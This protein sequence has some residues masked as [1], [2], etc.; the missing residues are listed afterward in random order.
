MSEQPN[1]GFSPESTPISIEQIIAENHARIIRMASELGFREDS[2]MQEIRA[3]GVKDE[4][5][6]ISY[7]NLILWRDLAEKEVD[8]ISDIDIR[9]IAQVGMLITQTLFY[10]EARMSDEFYEAVEDAI[11]YARTW[12]L[13]AV[14]AELDKL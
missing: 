1:E 13:D 14:V 12:K 6:Q 9:G 11:V 5:G 7:E 2:K 8:R 10:L 4:N 3:R